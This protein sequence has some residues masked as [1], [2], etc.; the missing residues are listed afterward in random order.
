MI[1][2]PNLLRARTLLVQSWHLSMQ[3]ASEGWTAGS[4]LAVDS[5]AMAWVRCGRAMGVE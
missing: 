1:T 4:R 2:S 3:I 5:I